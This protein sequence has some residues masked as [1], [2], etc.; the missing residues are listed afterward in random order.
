MGSNNLADNYFLMKIPFVSKK[1]LNLKL[2]E[3]DN[4]NKYSYKGIAYYLVNKKT[5]KIN[6]ELAHFDEFEYKPYDETMLISKEKLKK[7]IEEPSDCYI[8]LEK[9]G[10]DRKQILF[11]RPKEEGISTADEEQ[12]N[13]VNNFI[14]RNINTI[15]DSEKIITSSNPTGS[16]SDFTKTPI[17]IDFISKEEYKENYKYKI[18]INALKR[19]KKKDGNLYN[20][21]RSRF[22]RS[23]DIVRELESNAFEEITL[24]EF[25]MKNDSVY[26]LLSIMNDT[27]KINPETNQYIKFKENFKEIFSTFIDKATHS[28]ID[29]QA[30]MCVVEY[31]KNYISW[32]QFEVKMRGLFRKSLTLEAKNNN[33]KDS[34]GSENILLDDTSACH[35]INVKDIK[36]AKKPENYKL[37]ADKDNGLLLGEEIHRI[38]DKNRIT[39]DEDGNIITNIPE[40][41]YLSSKKI[42]KKILNKKRIKLIQERN[43]NYPINK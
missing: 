27:E 3:E 6:Y 16:E 33:L 34:V 18:F 7:G 19:A 30:D 32:E 13:F 35:I 31:N 5:N 26:N 38:F 24:E 10:L 28:Y 36:K 9:Q 2:F 23:V 15:L 11:K 1:Y 39:F 42:D 8:K 43:E 29:A 21:L 41:K 14:F 25:A 17:Y 40:Y 4:R 20:Y 37:I 12:I 22:C